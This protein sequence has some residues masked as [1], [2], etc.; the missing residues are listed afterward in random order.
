[1]SIN[2]THLV[3]HTDNS[4]QEGFGLITEYI[5]M[6]KK[7]NQ[8]ALAITDHNSL[9]G[10]FKFLKECH[11]NGIKPIVGVTMNL[12]P[13]SEN[14]AKDKVNIEYSNTIPVVWKG[15]I[16]KI[17][18]L[19]KNKK[20]M[21]NLQKL[22]EESYDVENYYNYPRI[23]ID[24]LKKYSDNLICLSGDRFSEIS[25]RIR[26]GQIEEAKKEAAILKEIFGEDFY[27]ELI[28][29]IDEPDNLLRELVKIA[30]SMDIKT[31]V[32]ND[33]FY[34]EQKDAN[35][36][37]KL[38]ALGNNNKIS[39]TPIDKGGLRFRYSEPDRWLKSSDELISYIKDNII[40]VLKRNN[41][42]FCIKEI[43]KGIKNTEEIVNKVEDIE[44][45]YNNDLRPPVFIP[46]RF[47]SPYEYIKYLIKEGYK[48]K[49][50][51][52]S[53]E[54]QEESKR[55]IK[56]ELEVLYSNDF[57]DYFITVKDTIDW[58]RSQNQEVGCGRGSVGGSELAYLL[59]ISRTD[60]IRFDL[61]FE[62]FI[63]P[64]RGPTYKIEYD[65]GT[66]EEV[67]IAE[68][69]IVDGNKKYIY[70]LKVGDTVSVDN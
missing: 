14:G 54:I 51:H 36:H 13:K 43:Q 60:P 23:D 65:D 70:Q 16:T 34:P 47:E 53:K 22:V 37:E 9:V 56:Q 10:A 58:T 40:P 29:I 8:T 68:S 17:R 66:S 41:A 2:F 39:E 33:V 64:G 63:S 55:K 12:A 31:V 57:I 32:T 7:A 18:L 1:M 15:S 59:D 3:V 38:L 27:I 30:Q 50:L 24:I 5:E 28:P 21:L 69:K 26:A 67:N 19:A 62:R 35:I 48:K 46:E 44:L 49:R 42:D 4:L 20:G 52:C 45:E 11:S 61:M 25:C 6:A